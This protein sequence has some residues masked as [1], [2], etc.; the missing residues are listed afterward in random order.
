MLVWFGSPH[1]DEPLKTGNLWIA[2]GK[3]VGRSDLWTFLYMKTRPSKGRTERDRFSIWEQK[4]Q[5]W[6]CIDCPSLPFLL[7]QTF[8]LIFLGS[9]IHFGSSIQYYIWQVLVYTTNSICAKVLKS[10]AAVSVA[11]IK[12]LLF[13]V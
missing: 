4:S 12:D 5:L 8:F 3:V 2:A 13:Q 1:T 9:K 10:F 6:R 11:N 7:F